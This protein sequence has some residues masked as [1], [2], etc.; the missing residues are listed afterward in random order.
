MNLLSRRSRMSAEKRPGGFW[1]AC[2]AHFAAARFAVIVLVL[3]FGFSAVF[4]AAFHNPQPHQVKVAIV[5]PPQGLRQAR[6]ALDPRPVYAVP[7]SA[8]GAARE[9]LRADE[10]H[11]AVATGRILLASA[12]GF[13]ASQ[14]T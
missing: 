5:G 2:A 3:L 9:A 6:A 14:K 4:A 10:V 12:S 1:A 13:V 11:G 7:Y 8:A